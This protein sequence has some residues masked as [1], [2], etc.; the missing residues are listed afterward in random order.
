MESFLHPNFSH[1]RC[2]MLRNTLALLWLCGLTI[3]IFLGTY[4]FEYYSF[5]EYGGICSNWVEVFSLILC[6]L[7]PLVF[8][9]VSFFASFPIVLVLAI[10]LRALIFSLSAVSCC[11][12]IGTSCWLVS[13]FML[14]GDS[15]I[16]SI[17]WYILYCFIGSHIQRQ[18]VLICAILIVLISLFDYM[19]IAPFMAKLI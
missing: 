6:R 9:F 7:L 1:I 3:G 13:F 12:C 17:Y 2:T 10:F 19:Y 5:V 4:A 8:C 18:A 14:A 11:L 16:L 15:L